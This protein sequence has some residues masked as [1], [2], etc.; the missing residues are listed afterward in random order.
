MKEKITTGKD[1]T[2]KDLRKAMKL[3]E[4]CGSNPSRLLMSQS[5]KDKIVRMLN[6]H[7]INTK[8]NDGKDYVL[9]MEVIVHN[10]LSENVAY[11]E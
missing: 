9:G 8:G 4:D 5:M 7:G 1:I 11:I 6:E 10:E 2:E 3:L